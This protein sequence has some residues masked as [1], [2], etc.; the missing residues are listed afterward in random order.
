MR[1]V[2]IDTDF[3]DTAFEKKMVTEAGIEFSEY[4]GEGARKPA[5]LIEHLK[6]ADGAITSYGQFTAEV[7]EALPHLLVVSKTGTGVD[8]I[9]VEAA[10]KNGT[11]VCNVPGYGTEVVSDHAIALALSVLRRIVEVDADVKNDI[12]DFRRRRP[13]GQVHGRTFGVVGYGHI[14]RACARKAAG[15]GFDVRIWDRHGIP[16]RFSPEGFEYMALDD[17]ISTSDVVSFHTALTPETENLLD[18]KRI[19]TMKQD[20]IVVNTSRGGVVDTDALAKAL[21][22]GKLWGAGLDVFENEPLPA[23][24]PIRKAPNTVLT[25][26][27]AYWSE[28]AAIELR[29]R[30]TQ[31]AIDVVLGKKPEN[32]VN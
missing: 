7:F 32:A 3:G 1:I 9:D 17:L 19:A 12:W 21:E 14:G 2:A 11:I 22:A 26:H 8:N 28:E 29:T 25:S 6:D 5:E 10:T 23:D 16:G 31:N 27:C 24:A 15:L 4:N 18:E 30:C 13:F 20:A